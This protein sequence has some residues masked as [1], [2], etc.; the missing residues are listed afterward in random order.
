[1]QVRNEVLSL[2]ALKWRRAGAVGVGS[3]LG[4]RA[5]RAASKFKGKQG[6]WWL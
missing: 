3:D 1:M 4:G 2:E 6:V 5:G